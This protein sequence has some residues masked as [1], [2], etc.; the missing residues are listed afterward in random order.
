[1]KEQPSSLHHAVR[2]F[3]ITEKTKPNKT[4]LFRK[5]DTAWEEGLHQMLGYVSSICA[6]LT[7]F[8]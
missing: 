5:L 8:K 1:M 6:F 4:K 7:C 3:A 2:S